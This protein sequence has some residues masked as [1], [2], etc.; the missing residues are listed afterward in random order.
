M[1]AQKIAIR[2]WSNTNGTWRGCNR[3]AMLY[4]DMVYPFMRADSPTCRLTRIGADYYIDPYDWDMPKP[5]KI[6][7][8]FACPADEA[9]IVY[10]GIRVFVNSVDFNHAR[11]NWA[12]HREVQ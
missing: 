7:W 6:S 3:P 12:R 1:Y 5:S 9:E 2:T 10:Y 11:A 8:D 4:G